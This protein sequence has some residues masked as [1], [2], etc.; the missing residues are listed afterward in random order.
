M[1]QVLSSSP[2]IAGPTRSGKA[3]PRD[4]YSAGAVELIRGRT[5]WGRGF[6]RLWLLASM[7]FIVAVAVVASRDIDSQFENLDLPGVVGPTAKFVPARCDQARGVMG[8]DFKPGT[9]SPG[10]CWYELSSFRPRYP[11]Y[12]RLSNSDLEAQQYAAAGRA[13]PA[14]RLLNWLAIAIGV[15]FFT[16]ILGTAMGWALAGFRSEA[17]PAALARGRLGP[18]SS[19]ASRGEAVRFR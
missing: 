7:I 14:A 17:G 9:A 1:V 6:F 4:E 8:K 11:E 19:S 15:P 12:D 10:V 2:S 13:R 5:N 3:I 16:L 18:T